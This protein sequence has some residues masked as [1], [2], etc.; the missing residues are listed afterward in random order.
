M[1]IDPTAADQ[2]AVR[3]QGFVASFALFR[4]TWQEADMRLAPAQLLKE[5]V[6]SA[7]GKCIKIKVA[8]NPKWQCLHGIEI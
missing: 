6:L 8:A 4:P 2:R 1:S 5:E 3:A 7:V